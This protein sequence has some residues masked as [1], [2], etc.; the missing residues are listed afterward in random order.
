MEIWLRRS[1]IAYGPVFP[2][3]TAAGTIE[4]RLTG[5][6]V[7]KIL[8]RRAALVGL[9]APDGGRLSPHGLRAGFMMAA[10]ARDNAS[11]ARAEA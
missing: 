1:Q 11:L 4:G 10:A 3:L 2:R 8:R 5:N 7:W 9:Q 6:G